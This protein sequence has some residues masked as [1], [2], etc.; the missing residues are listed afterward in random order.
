[1]AEAEARRSEDA[2]D[3]AQRLDALE[4]QVLALSH[5]AGDACRSRR[6]RWHPR[7][8]D[9]R[10]CRADGGRRCQR[11]DVAL[12]LDVLARMAEALERS[13]ARTEDRLAAVRDA[14]AVPVADLQAAL[15]AR[16]DRTEAQL[17]ELGAALD[18]S[19]APG[20]TATA[21]PGSVP[22]PSS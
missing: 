6:I 19:P 2:L 15:M 21:G 20:G 11:E 9:G 8:P 16:A 14:A 1:M 5:N 3:V 18:A 4:R 7:G 17:A 13:D 22:S 12:A 10:P